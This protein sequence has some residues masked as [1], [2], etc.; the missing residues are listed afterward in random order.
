[1]ARR[2]F[3]SYKRDHA[4]S[5]AAVREI[6][7]KLGGDFAILRD[8]SMGPGRPWSAEL[9]RWLLECDAGIALVSV[10]ANSADWC[11]REWTVLAARNQTVG[12][13]VFPLH[14]DG[15]VISTGILAA[16]TRA[17]RHESR[18]SRSDLAPPWSRPGTSSGSEARPR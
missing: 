11:R 12:L 18:R 6:E 3:V 4:P 14:V 7:A 1:M 13:P 9:Y 16:A 8:V 15:K 17:A 2:I 5:D 10:E